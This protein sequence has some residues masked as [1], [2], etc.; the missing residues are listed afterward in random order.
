MTGDNDINIFVQ[1]KPQIIECVLF[2]LVLILILGFFLLFEMH[3]N[4][5]VVDFKPLIVT[6][7]TDSEVLK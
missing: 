7:L 1:Y 6:V 5:Y 3:F 2:K 4:I